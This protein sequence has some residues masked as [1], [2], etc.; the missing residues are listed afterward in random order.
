MPALNLPYKAKVTQ[1]QPDIDQGRLLQIQIFDSTSSLRATYSFDCGDP[2]LSQ[3]KSVEAL[4]IQL[5]AGLVA[6]LIADA[7]DVGTGLQALSLSMGG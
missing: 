6:A 3:W 4:M 2:S 7:G 5:Q 1:A